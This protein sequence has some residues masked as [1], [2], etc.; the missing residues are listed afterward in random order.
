MGQG[1]VKYMLPL[2]MSYIQK[3]RIKIC[4]DSEDQC[5][6]CADPCIALRAKFGLVVAKCLMLVEHLEALGPGAEVEAQD[7]LAR[8]TLDIVLMA[9]FGIGSS[10]IGDPQPVPLLKELHYAMDESFRCGLG[11]S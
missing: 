3:I 10:T 4:H 11:E 2:C 5:G 9:G 7:M 6:M 1:V 8:L